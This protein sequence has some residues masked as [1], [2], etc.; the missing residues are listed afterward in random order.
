MDN[1]RFVF[2]YLWISMISWERDCGGFLLE[3]FPSIKVSEYQN[4]KESFFLY[5]WW[6]FLV[7]AYV[8]SSVCVWKLTYKLFVCFF[9]FLDEVTD[10]YIMSQEICWLKELPYCLVFNDTSSLCPHVYIVSCVDLN[11]PI[12]IWFKFLQMR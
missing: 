6:E 2:Y 1:H 12:F 7:F 3:Q 10:L 5:S 8:I 4:P 9:H 11:N